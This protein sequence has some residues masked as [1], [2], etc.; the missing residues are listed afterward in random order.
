MHIIVLEFELISH[1]PE[2]LIKQGFLKYDVSQLG[3]KVFDHPRL[4][5]DELHDTIIVMSETHAFYFDSDNY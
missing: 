3:N 4:A 1:F 2:K 5:Y